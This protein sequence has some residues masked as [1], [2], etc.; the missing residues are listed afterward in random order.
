M[1]SFLEGLQE[2]PKL[3]QITSLETGL[4]CI[5]RYYN[6]GHI[7]HELRTWGLR[8]HHRWEEEALVGEAVLQYRGRID[9]WFLNPEIELSS[10]LLTPSL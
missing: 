7:V 5:I 10:N 4:K 9:T 1:D 2:F 3:K 8:L 6:H